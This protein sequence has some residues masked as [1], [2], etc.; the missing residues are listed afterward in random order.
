[1][2]PIRYIA[3]IVLMVYSVHTKAQEN[4]VQFY[5]NCFLYDSIL[6]FINP[7]MQ[8]KYPYI[9]F[10]ENKYVFPSEN[11]PSFKLFF[12]K[13][14]SLVKLKDRQLNVYHIGGSHIQADVYSHRMRIYLQKYADNLKGPRGLLF[15]FTLAGTNNPYHYKVDSVGKWT[16]MRN[17][18]IKD[19]SRLGLLGMSASTRD[20]LAGF[21]IYRNKYD[22]LNHY[23][24]RIKVYHNLN[25]NYCLHWKDTANVNSI[26][27]DTLAG[28]TTFHLNNLVDTARF[29]I[30]KV[31]DDTTLF[32]TYGVEL[33]NDSPGI[34]YN[35]I[36]VN[37]ASFRS[38]LRCQD[39]GKQLKEL[40]PDMFII[41]IGTNDANTTFDD[42]RPD[43]FRQRYEAMI[44]T[45]REAN[46]DCAI[47]LTVP[48]DCYY[49]GKH[50]NKNTARM[51]EVIYELAKQYQYAVW[52]FYTIMGGQGSSQK[53]F[54]DKLMIRDKIH[55][56]VEGYRL[57]GD[58]FYEAF[59]KYI[60]EYEYK[61]QMIG[62]GQN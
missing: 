4:R 24:N 22:T 11:S 19:T 38:Y 36:G 17:V 35:S 9:N 50:I 7:E 2:K 34:I 45:I 30:Y 15:P 52:D 42:F 6:G 3:L 54:T 47:L 31:G 55:F 51:K 39:F 21:S 29:V 37:G 8:I 5:E 41:S 16:G 33:M 57:K 1:M 53:W 40:R 12:E 60:D 23:F 56:T 44:K 20:I 14:D 32:T 25:E 59:L 18:I 46:P 27:T 58:L 28:Y 10:G 62:L 48:N 61:R 49:R 26:F 13:F 43:V